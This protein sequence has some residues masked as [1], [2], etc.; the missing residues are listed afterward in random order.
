LFFCA[1]PRFVRI[2]YQ[3]ECFFSASSLKRPVRGVIP[4]QAGIHCA[5]GF[6]A[7]RIAATVFAGAK[8]KA[9][10]AVDPEPQ[11]DDEHC[12]FVLIRI[13]G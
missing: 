5:A 10:G 12:V 3:K 11:R 13:L 4:A 2:E 1:H 8:I 6:N 7:K 9:C